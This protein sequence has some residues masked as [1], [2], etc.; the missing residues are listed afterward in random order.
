MW[1]AGFYARPAPAAA[2]SRDPAVHAGPE[3]GCGCLPT[4]NRQPATGNRRTANG[5]RRTATGWFV[6]PAARWFMMSGPCTRRT[7]TRVHHCPSC[8]RPCSPSWAECSGSPPT[9]SR[10]GSR[11]TGQ[12]AL[13]R[14]PCSS[15]W[16]WRRHGGHG[17]C[18]RPSRSTPR[19]RPPCTSGSRSPRPARPGRRSTVIRAEPPARTAQGRKSS[20]APRR[21]RPRTPWRR[22]SSPS[23]STGRRRP[24]G[25][26]RMPWRRCSPGYGSRS[27]R[28]GRCC[29]LLPRPSGPVP[30]RTRRGGRNDGLT[31]EDCSPKWWFGGV[32]PRGCGPRSPA[33]EP[34]PEPAGPVHHDPE[35]P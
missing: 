25:R 16:G 17:A 10:P 33:R 8:G 21:R 18:R 29:R 15:P 13:R 24:A 4:G 12:R 35:T 31:P 19:P 14:R 3:T 7:R 20:S 23:S 6:R 32:R 2:V 22:C 9:T 34:A 1:P 26:L 30:R 28:C 5:E 27:T 11:P